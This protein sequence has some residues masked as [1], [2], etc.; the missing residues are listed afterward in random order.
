[1]FSV[2]ACLLTLALALV[3][4]ATEEDAAAETE[5]PA[6]PAAAP[7]PPEVQAQ[8]DSGN[9]AFRDDDYETALSHFRKA[10]EDAPD[11]PAPLYGVYLASAALGDSALADS[12]AAVLQERAP[13]LLDGMAHPTGDTPADPHAGLATMMAPD[14]QADTTS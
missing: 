6:G 3:G 5:A 4:C 9:M 13:Y 8:V 10:L 14:S 12:V 11:R 1:M 7:L 2:G